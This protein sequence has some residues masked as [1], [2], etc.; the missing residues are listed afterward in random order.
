MWFR[1]IEAFLRRIVLFIGR[2][3]DHFIGD[4][5]DVNEVVWVT[6]VLLYLDVFGIECNEMYSVVEEHMS[7]SAMRS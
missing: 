2:G 3:D 4:E 7:W 5:G 6:I 1:R